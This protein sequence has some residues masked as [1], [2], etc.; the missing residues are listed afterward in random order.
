M[1]IAQFTCPLIVV[2]PGQ[3]ISASLWN[4]EWNN[5]DN[6]LNPQGVGSYSDTDSQMRASSDPFPSGTSRPTAL[7]G[8]LERL[9]YILDLVVGKTYWYEHPTL[10]LEQTNTFQLGHTHTGGADGTQI[11][12]GGIA[13]LAITTVKIADHA[14]TTGRINPQAVTSGELADNAVITSKIN[15]LA[16]TDAKVND[17]AVGKITGTFPVAQGGTGITTKMLC[18]V[19]WTG[20]GAAARVISH[21]LGAIPTI[22][23]AFPQ[24]GNLIPFYWGKPGGVEKNMFFYN[25]GAPN[26]PG[27]NYINSPTSSQFTITADA[28]INNS[29]TH[30]LAVLLVTQ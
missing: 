20:N 13:D 2:I 16:V 11:P 21:T 4:N 30:Y 9:R 17:V 10:S 23:I 24:E 14:V 22:I 5:I 8:E 1:S 28:A 27:I 3:I 19:A 15:A 18:I 7:N 6:N 29:G 25:S 26:P 12:T